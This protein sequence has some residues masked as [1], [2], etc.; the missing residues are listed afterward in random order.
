MGSR[1]AAHFANAGIGVL[2]LDMGDRARTALSAL[3]ETKPPAYYEEQ[4]AD[5]IEAGNFENELTR[6]AECNW[7][8]EAVAEDL[9]IKR[10][11][12]Q[13]VAEVRRAD[14]I[15]TT[16]TSGLP[17]AQIAQGLPA[18]FRKHWLGV[19]FF[20]PPR[21]MQ[22]VE[23]IRTPD[24]DPAVVGALATFIE[25]QLGKTVVEAN[26]TPNFIANRIGLFA[27]L[28]SARLM[29]QFGMTIEE[30]DALTGPA[31]GW[32]NTGTF[33]LVD[34]IGLDVIANMAA[35][36]ATRVQDERPEV[37]LPDFLKTL[38]ERGWL[39][40]KSG[41]GCYRKGE[42][43]EV[44]DWQTGHYRPVQK[45]DPP[46]CA[47][48][49]KWRLLSEIWNYAAFRLGEI[50]DDF[51]AIDAAMKAGFNW[52][53]GP[54]EMWDRAGLRETSERMKAEGVQLAPALIQ[55]LQSEANSW[56]PEQ[57]AAPALVVRNAGASLVD[58]GHGVARIQFHTKMNSIDDSIM[59][60][61]I[62]QLA[63]NS[64]SV[65]NFRAFVI[66]GDGPHFSAGANLA[67]ILQQIESQDWK[68]LEQF[69]TRFQQMTRAVKRCK[70]PVVAAV[71][72]LC[73]GGGAEIAMHAS[74][75]Q[76]HAELS[77]GLVEA[78][79]GLVPGGGG[80]KEL[81]LRAADGLLQWSEA[82]KLLATAWRSS[83]ARQ[84][85][86]AQLLLAA[87]GITMNRQNLLRDAKQLALRLVPNYSAPRE[88][89]IRTPE[90]PLLLDS[91]AGH[92]ATVARKLADV[93]TCGLPPGSWATEQDFLDA[94]REAFLSLCREP[95][96][97]DRIAYTLKTG[98]PLRN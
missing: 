8:I 26:D 43:I 72:G 18:E 6:V 35:N 24:T 84:A 20:N 5:L 25:E 90:Q 33:R 86:R 85:Q 32:P 55:L 1:I 48:E 17:V 87:D 23:I 77:M 68:C 71:H 66:G 19:H 47:E 82:F 49:F 75:R 97:K 15:V 27:L 96:T 61:L 30:V 45:A 70:R 51:E 39:G 56:Y 11:L 83:S 13:R 91:Y 10:D 41:Q 64:T 4:C 58:A 7:I 3:Q 57:P 93:L 53:W 63:D 16:N 59:S 67:F 42:T 44:F 29:Q 46:A 36:F 31:I 74:A 22:L 28:N 60:F 54:F 2:L 81:A 14:T 73:L 34:L 52:Q 92:D 21:Y 89:T 40:N 76:A 69:I 50:S 79:V 65:E 88:R 94:E 80:C 12:M 9:A 95:K 78:A 37:T 98:K 62:E 38:V